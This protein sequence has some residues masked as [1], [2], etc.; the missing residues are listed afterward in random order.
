MSYYNHA[1]RIA[2]TPSIPMERGNGAARQLDT[3]SDEDIDP[4]PRNPRSLYNQNLAQDKFCDQPDARNK[5]TYVD[6]YGRP[7]FGG[8]PVKR[9]YAHDQLR[10]RHGGAHSSRRPLADISPDND[11]AMLMSESGYIGYTQ[12][13]RTRP[14]FYPRPPVA[15]SPQMPRQPH[16]ND[17]YN[18]GQDL[19]YSKASGMG[20]TWETHIPDDPAER[21]SAA[22][23][24][25]AAVMKRR[26]P[27]DKDGKVP[28]R[29]YG[30][31]DPENIKIVNLYEND[32]LGFDEICRQLNNQRVRDGRNPTLTVCGIHARYNRTAPLLFASERKPFVPLRD[33]RKQAKNGEQDLP[34][35]EGPQGGMFW[36]AERDT[37]LVEIAQQ[38][39]AEK[40]KTVADLLSEET[41]TNLSVKQ[42]VNRW[43]IL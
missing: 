14:M 23:R 20:K 5:M 41:N 12:P 43:R 7:I 25:R 37:R 32:H 9:N 15:T 31:N 17:F 34:L 30:I 8:R 4:T 22:K 29:A 27:I 21:V 19:G 18:A 38:V 10:E 36:N 42:V 3:D 24:G 11:G 26:L 16:P 40:W 2:D 33:R 39:D 6:H 35:D 13:H 1:T 28:K